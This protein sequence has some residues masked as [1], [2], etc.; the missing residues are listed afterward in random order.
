MRGRRRA[1]GCSPGSTVER[2]ERLVAGGLLGGEEVAE[3]RDVV[4]GIDRTGGRAAEP[5]P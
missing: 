2:P 3:R 5:H 1:T 4:I